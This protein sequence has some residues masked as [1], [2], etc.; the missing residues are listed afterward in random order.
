MS[1]VKD[2]KN[3][4]A[5][6]RQISFTLKGDIIVT[7]PLFIYIS[8]NIFTLDLVLNY[9]SHFINQNLYLSKSEFH[10]FWST[11]LFGL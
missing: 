7:S 4:R 9:E 1:N 11:S 10:L 3:E 2:K 8:L 6:Y 5:A